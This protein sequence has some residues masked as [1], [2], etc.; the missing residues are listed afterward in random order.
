[1]IKAIE[2]MATV[3][4]TAVTLAPNPPAR[5]APPTQY[6]GS[7]SRYDPGVMESIMDWRHTNGIPAGFNPYGDYNGFI[8]VLDC[9]N[10]GKVAWVTVTIEGVT[11]EPKRVYVADCTSPGTSAARWMV[12]N[13][14]A[15]ELD[16]QAWVDWGIVD[17][18]GA[19]VEIVIEE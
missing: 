11:Y 19:W 1:M 10:V 17:G 7:L 16:Y 2:L 14:I 12:S 5:P 8:A 18:R 3:I 6:E 9:R 4:M 15:A 13:S